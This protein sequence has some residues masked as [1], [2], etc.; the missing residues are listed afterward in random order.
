M[1]RRE[2]LLRSG[3][4]CMGLG[5]MAG[6]ATAGTE[7]EPSRRPN[8]IYLLAD[9]LRYQSC[10]YAGDEKACSPAGAGGPAYSSWSA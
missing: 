1:N 3:L 6:C 9:Q 5:V 10:G 2:F 8:I 4:S 7:Q